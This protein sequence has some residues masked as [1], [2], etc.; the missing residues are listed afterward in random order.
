MSGIP[1]HP[2]QA[3]G[4]QHMRGQSVCLAPGEKHPRTAGGTQSAGLLANMSGI[5]C[6]PILVS[7]KADSASSGGSG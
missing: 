2:K 4:Q 7:S 6:I 5:L 3:S 1:Y